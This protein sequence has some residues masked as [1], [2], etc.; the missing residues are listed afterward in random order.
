MSISGQSYKSH[1]MWKKLKGSG[2]TAHLSVLTQ[3][4]LIE[5]VLTDK[6]Q[7]RLDNNPVTP[8]TYNV[9]F[10]NKKLGGLTK[11]RKITIATNKFG[12]HKVSCKKV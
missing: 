1:K 5:G 4:F 10:Y 3:Q 7:E 12:E 2:G 6:G 9:S 8:K 11:K